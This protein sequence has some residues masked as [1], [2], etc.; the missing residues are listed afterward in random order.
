MS[1][2]SFC[3]PKKERLE[4]TTYQFST[5]DFGLGMVLV[6][7]AGNSTKR[8][9]PFNNGDKDAWFY[10]SKSAIEII[11]L[12][13]EQVEKEPF[14]KPIVTSGFQFNTSNFDDGW[15][16]TVQED[17]VEVRKGDIK[18]LL[19]Y[20]GNKINP[21]NTDLPVVCEAAWNALVAP[22]YS[23]MENYQLTPGVI[24]YERP[25]FAQANLTDNLTG[26]KVFVALFKKGISGWI[27]IIT[28]DKNS[29]LQNFGL[30]ITKIDPYVDSKIWLPL[31]NLRSYNKFAVAAGDL[32]GKWSTSFTG[33][34]QYV[35][36]YTG[37]DA[38]MSTH[39]SNEVFVFTGSSYSWELKVASG[40]V[41][42]I[43]FQGA[44]SN[45]KFTV[46]NNWQVHFSEIEK[47]ARTYNAYFSCVKGARLLWLQDTGYGDYS[48]F[49]KVE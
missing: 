49:G 28:T 24:E 35:N 32:K 29:F 34:Q 12:P 43:K 11:K 10:P 44:K 5:H 40:F 6:L 1:G 17:W 23:N 37:N 20:P 21:A 41:G 14:T 45:G 2:V 30:D 7:K 4:K 16:S 42:N 47:K 31:Q 26:K 38:G 13:G 33:M 48:S 39:S 22:R 18:V 36:I 9:G 8:D 3:L 27:E 25:Y 15:T 19:H 46:P